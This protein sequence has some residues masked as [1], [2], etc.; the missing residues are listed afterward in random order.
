MT[1]KR[2]IPE[3]VSSEAEVRLSGIHFVTL[4]RSR[5]GS[6]LVQSLRSCLAGM[7][8]DVCAVSKS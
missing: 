6:R 3:A 2:V 7:T 8:T 1:M 4:D 5:N